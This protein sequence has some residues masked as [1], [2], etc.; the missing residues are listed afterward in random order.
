MEGNKSMTKSGNRAA[1]IFPSSGDCEAD[2]AWAK[3]VAERDLELFF[4]GTDERLQECLHAITGKQN[5]SDAE[6]AYF[7]AVLRSR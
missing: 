3:L 2:S 5:P 1:S 7:V 4:W 6:S